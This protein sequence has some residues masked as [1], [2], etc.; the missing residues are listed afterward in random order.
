MIFAA[1]EVS[2]VYVLLDIPDLI[3]LSDTPLVYL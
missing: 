2:L 3:S 1:I